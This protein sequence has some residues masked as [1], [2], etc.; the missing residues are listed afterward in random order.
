MATQP[1]RLGDLVNYPMKD[2]AGGETKDNRLDLAGGSAA[3]SSP[4]QVVNITLGVPIRR[5]AIELR[6]YMPGPHR[7]FL[8]CLEH[9]INEQGSIR[10]FV[11]LQESLGKDEMGERYNEALQALKDFRNS[12]MRI[13]TQ[14]IVVPGAKAKKAEDLNHLDKFDPRNGYPGLNNWHVLKLGSA[15]DKMD[16]EPKGTGGTSPM[17]FLKGMRDLTVMSM[18]RKDS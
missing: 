1:Q 18:L 7:R 9:R 15:V 17:P 13:V 2:T 5:E 8:E 14:F 10:N 3:Q 16:E 12:H 11:L 6:G 4:L